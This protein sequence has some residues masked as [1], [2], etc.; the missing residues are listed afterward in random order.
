MFGL[1]WFQADPDHV[2]PR[3]G[4][5]VTLR[6]SRQ[7][8]SEFLQQVE[9]QEYTEKVVATGCNKDDLINMEVDD[10]CREVGMS[11]VHAMRLDRVVKE[12]IFTSRV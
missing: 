6:D 2:H 1:L 12:C 8:V 9:L 11:R 3:Y 4:S 7:D 5:L 10:L